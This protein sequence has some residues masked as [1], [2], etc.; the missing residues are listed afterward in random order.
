MES[1]TWVKGG[2]AELLW[3]AAKWCLPRGDELEKKLLGEA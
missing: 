2:L 1:V 3:D